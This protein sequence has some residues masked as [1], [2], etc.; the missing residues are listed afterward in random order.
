MIS[1]RIRE[2][3]DLKILEY[4]RYHYQ[5]N[6]LFPTYKKVIKS[7]LRQIVIEILISN[8]EVFINKNA[9]IKKSEYRFLHD[10]E[11]DHLLVE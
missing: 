11:K 2:D 3:I 1:I 7:G 10:L 4:Y 8:R 6:L 5:E 9:K